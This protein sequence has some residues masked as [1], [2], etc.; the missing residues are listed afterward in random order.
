MYKRTAKLEYSLLAQLHGLAYMPENFFEN[1]AHAHTNPLMDND[2]PNVQ[3]PA[4]AGEPA[5][6]RDEA[7]P[8][9]V[10]VE[11]NAHAV[12]QPP[13]QDQGELAV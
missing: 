10:L 8:P 1:L 2:Q 6:I 4:A 12:P 9:E 11:N 7:M 3:Y 5:E 13:A